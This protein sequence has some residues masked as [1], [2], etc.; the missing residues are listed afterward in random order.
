[1]SGLSFEVFR[2]FLGNQIRLN[3]P[4]NI[5]SYIKSSANF[6]GF[7]EFTEELLAEFL[8]PE[9]VHE[10][11]PQ[12]EPQPETQPE[13]QPFLLF[14]MGNVVSAGSHLSPEFHVIFEGWDGTV[15]VEATLSAGLDQHGWVSNPKVIPLERIWRFHQTIRLTTDS[16]DCRPGDYLIDFTC[17]FRNSGIHR[18]SSWYGSFKF[19]VAVQRQGELIISTEGNSLVNLSGDL[20][21]LVQDF[22][23]I[24][25]DG[26]ANS[27]VNLQAFESALGQTA[28]KKADA[29]TTMTTI[30]L[31]RI[32]DPEPVVHRRIARPCVEGR[33]DLPDGR[34]VLIY[35]RDQVILGRNRPKRDPAAP[36]DIAL[37]LWP[38]N[39]V[40]AKLNDLISRQHL[41]VTA[42]N[43]EIEFRD[44]RSATSAE[45]SPAHVNGV[46]LQ[47]SRTVSHS[48][49]VIEYSTSVARPLNSGG[50]D[51]G[52]VNPGI[53]PGGIHSERRLIGLS[54]RSFQQAQGAV[55]RTYE[56]LRCLVGTVDF[57]ETWR[58]HEA[59]LDAVLIERGRNMDELNGR[60]AYLLVLGMVM[61]GT[62]HDCPFRIPH[63]SIR[64]D[65]AILCHWDGQF[66]ILPLE[67]AFVACDGRTIQPGKI[68]TISIG[69][70][71]QLGDLELT[72][73]GAEQFGLE[74]DSRVIP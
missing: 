45:A 1:M 64:P 21:S 11:Q 54:L 4:P 73:D 20:L 68:G 5:E 56:S 63:R 66:R 10:S 42:R 61:M 33:F 14:Q 58:R 6:A 57:N 55:Q 47:G 35:A 34:R 69:S 39:E 72:F 62:N 46:L 48:S 70:K 2:Q 52:G 26:A 30:K 74:G 65:H 36:T 44:Q 29:T 8:A 37:R 67:E 49:G 51:H 31:I 19:Q 43:G 50:V 16:N 71:L 60:E 27:L 24:R 53:N 12:P 32:R 15:E 17:H 41:W 3:P 18:D 59:G 7:A 13:P 40:R 9:H 38:E 25:I 22:R 28:Q 23:T